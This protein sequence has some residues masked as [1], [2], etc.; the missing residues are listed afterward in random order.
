MASSG[1]VVFPGPIPE[2]FLCPLW[3]ELRGESNLHSAV[4]TMLICVGVGFCRI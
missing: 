3:M 4:S 1:E 2:G